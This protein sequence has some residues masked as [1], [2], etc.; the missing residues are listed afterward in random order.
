MAGGHQDSTRA[1]KI[2]FVE[3]MYAIDVQAVPDGEDWSYEV[4]LDGYRCLAG[5]DSAGVSLWSRRGNLFTDQFPQIARACERLPAGTLVDGEIVAIDENGRISFN[6]LQ[7]HRAGAQALLFYV[8]DVIACRGRS[9][10]RLPLS[11]RRQVLKGLFQQRPP[12]PIGLSD[13]FESD[14][15]SLITIVAEYGFEGIVA[16]RTSSYYE[17]GKRNGAWLKYKIHKGQ[18]FVIGGYTGGGPLDALIVGYYEGDKLMYAGKVRNGFVPHVR[19]EVAQQIR[20]LRVDVCPFANLPEKKRTIWAL[21]RE[22][23]KNC[24]WLRPELVARIE[25]ADWTPDGHLRHAR[26]VSLR[27]D[28]QPH[29]V[30]REDALVS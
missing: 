3:P 9:L 11:E 2:A 1:A 28:K 13:V 25:F 5:R 8:F 24:I 4:K 30:V 12:A 21:T 14:P 20:D 10:L 15:E 27:D 16:K 26:F 17:P 7:N 6:L 18:E 19:R 29:K 22:E 23:M